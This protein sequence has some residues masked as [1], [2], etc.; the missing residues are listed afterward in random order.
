MQGAGDVAG[1]QCLAAQ[2]DAG[3]QKFGRGQQTLAFGRLQLLD[4]SEQQH[5]VDDRLH[6]P[7][8][9]GDAVGEAPAVAKIEN[10]QNKPGYKPVDWPQPAPQAPAARMAGSLWQP[11]SRAFFKDQRAARVGDI[12]R[13]MVR[14]DDKATVNNETE[15]KRDNT[16]K[17]DSPETMGLAKPLTAWLPGSANPEKLLDMRGQ[18]KNK[19]TGRI[20]RQDTIE[21]EVAAMITQILPNGNMVISGKQEIRVNYEL[22]EIA[23]DGVVRPEDIRSDNTIQSSQVAEARIT[24]GG[25]GQLT[26][27]QQPRW[28]SQVL[29]VLSP[30]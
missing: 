19:G 16:E 26:D 22:R 24:Y 13:V 10:P 27:I 11:G 2:I 23:I 6:S 20:T 9:F 12:L 7:R 25:R 5:A 1:L 17:L 28:G 3:L 4:A 30:F 18:V 14:I 15:R 29:D 21:T 8:L